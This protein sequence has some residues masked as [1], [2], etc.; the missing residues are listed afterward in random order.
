M[1]YLLLLTPAAFLLISEESCP[2]LELDIMF[3]Y[4]CYSM[5]KARLKKLFSL[6]S[7]K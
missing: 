3:V 4:G 7:L 2:P 5:L 6:I 1:D